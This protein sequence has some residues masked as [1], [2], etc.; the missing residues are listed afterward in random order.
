MRSPF[1]HETYPFKYRNS[2]FERSSIL[3]MKK[4]LY[5]GLSYELLTFLT[6][7]SSAVEFLK[8]FSSG[9][10]DVKIQFDPYYL[11]SDWLQT[12]S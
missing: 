3:T 12:H 1:L 9:E 7:F 11:I 5:D 2:T 6:F 8:P 4:T 10:S